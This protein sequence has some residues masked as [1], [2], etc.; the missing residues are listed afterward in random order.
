MAPELLDHGALDFAPRASC[1]ERRSQ[2]R[3]GLEAIRAHFCEGRPMPGTRGG[4][5]LP[6]AFGRGVLSS[7]EFVSARDCDFI[8]GA[9]GVRRFRV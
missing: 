9:G 2:F 1:P 5:K 4:L 3:A 7:E 8:Y 6:R